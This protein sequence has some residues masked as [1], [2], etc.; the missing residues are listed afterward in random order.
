MA[1]GRLQCG[2]PLKVDLHTQLNN[3]RAIGGRKGAKVAVDL[4]PRR[5]KPRGRIEAGELRVVE[6]V[7]KLEAELHVNRLANG[8][9][10][11]DGDVP[12]VDAW[13]ADHRLGRVSDSAYGRQLEHAGVEVLVESA[14]T[15]G[16]H[17]TTMRGP[18]VGEPVMSVAVTCGVG[19]L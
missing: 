18:S 11:E 2:E 19:R 17:R 12:V 4:V 3:T 8:E 1:P 9:I 7:V 5:V 10:L 6:G 15:L 14:L 16:K 13:T